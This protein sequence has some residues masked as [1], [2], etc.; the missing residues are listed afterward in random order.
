L[1]AAIGILPLTVFLFD[2]I[3]YRFGDEKIRQLTEL[4]VEPWQR[5]LVVN[6]LLI[7]KK[8][9]ASDFWEARQHV[10]DLIEF[11]ESTNDTKYLRNVLTMPSLRFLEGRST[12]LML[13]KHTHWIR[14]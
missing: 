2:L 8:A 13:L 10:R 3:T 1:I 11:L 14:V 9:L 7:K 5:Y 4:Y 12:G 6:V